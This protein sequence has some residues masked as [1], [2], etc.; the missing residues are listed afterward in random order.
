MLIIDTLIIGGIRFC[1]DK[2]VTAVDR[3]MN[4]DSAL[5]EELM[6]AQMR[7]ELGEIGQEEFE[8]V[9]TEMLA[10][11]REIRERQIARA[12]EVEE[13]GELKITGA[14]VSFEADEEH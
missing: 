14:D 9:E 6:A 4:D 5:R 12:D 11:I 1:L 13:A 3:E 10:R 8:A 7:Y 2:I